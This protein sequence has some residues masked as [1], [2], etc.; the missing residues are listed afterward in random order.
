M[1]EDFSKFDRDDSVAKDTT[2]IEL[3]R[4]VFGDKPGFHEGLNSYRDASIDLARSANGDRQQAQDGLGEGDLEGFDDA[5]VC[6]VQVRV[7]L[8]FAEHP[9]SS[10][11]STPHRPS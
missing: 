6:K 1:A 3:E 2:E 10:S 5:D 4:L 8:A 9:S 11:F 7:G